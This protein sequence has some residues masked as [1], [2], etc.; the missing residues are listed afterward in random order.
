[1]WIRNSFISCIVCTTWIAV[2]ALFYKRSLHSEQKDGNFGFG[3]KIQLLPEQKLKTN[4]LQEVV[5]SEAKKKHDGNLLP[6]EIEITKVNISSNVVAQKYEAEVKRT[7]NESS[8]AK[9]KNILLYTSFFGENQWTLKSM[10]NDL[11]ID[12]KCPVSNCYIT[13]DHKY[14][15]NIADFDAILFHMRDRFQLPDQSKRQKEQIYIMFL[16]ESPVNDRTSYGAY[17]GNQ[18]HRKINFHQW[19]Y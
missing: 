1:M 19:K 17:K 13:R 4:L 6:K 9:R 10:K 16:M 14:L 8:T 7:E 11:F 2:V 3:P 5:F 15:D 12:A 18:L